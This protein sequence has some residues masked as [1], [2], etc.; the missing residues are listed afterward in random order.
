MLP[1]DADVEASVSRGL[2]L[3]HAFP[4]SEAEA[5]TGAAADA[6]ALAGEVELAAHESF[7]P[8]GREV[9]TT[10][11]LAPGTLRVGQ[12]PIDGPRVKVARL[13]PLNS[14]IA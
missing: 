10:G 6:V 4:R 9:Q 7:E 2:F 11:E 14:R 12:Q 8:T 1:G 3:C 5:Q 13:S